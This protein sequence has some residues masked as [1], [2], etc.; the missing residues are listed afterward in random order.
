MNVSK[1]RENSEKVEQKG[2][3]LIDKCSSIPNEW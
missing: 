1:I 3:N 2:V